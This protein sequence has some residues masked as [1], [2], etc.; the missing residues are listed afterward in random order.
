MTA[1]ASIPPT[2]NTGKWTDGQSYMYMY[3]HCNPYLILLQTLVYKS[4]VLLSLKHNHHKATLNS[5]T[6]ITDNILWSFWGKNPN[7]Q[8]LS[9]HT[10]KDM[11]IHTYTH[12]YTVIQQHTQ[13]CT[14]RNYTYPSQQFPVHWSLLYESLYQ[15]HYQDTACHQSWTPLGQDTPSSPGHRKEHSKQ[16]LAWHFWLKEILHSTTYTCN[17]TLGTYM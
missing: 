1:S 5:Y 2:P 6:W 15:Q 17:Q 7:H 12:I 8:V 4:F 3:V 14:V 10:G 9:A 11:R 13:T 16:L